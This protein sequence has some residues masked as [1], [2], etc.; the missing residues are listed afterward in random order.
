[1][2][3]SVEA[4]AYDTWSTL[5]DTYPVGSMDE[6]TEWRNSLVDKIATYWYYMDTPSYGYAQDKITMID[7]KID[8]FIFL[9]AIS[10]TLMGV[11]LIFFACLFFYSRYRQEKKIVCHR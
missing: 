5:Y 1:M 11:S 10:N 3:W 4:T 8:I 6:E 9:A 2:K 7:N